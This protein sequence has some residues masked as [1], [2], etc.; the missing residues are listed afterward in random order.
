MLTIFEMGANV[1]IIAECTAVAS[2]DPAAVVI[3]NEDNLGSSSAAAVA[4][5]PAVGVSVNPFW[6][7]S[8]AKPVSAPAAAGVCSMYVVNALATADAGSGVFP[9]LGLVALAT[10]FADAGVK[11]IFISPRVACVSADAIAGVCV[12][13]IFP[14]AAFDTAD[15]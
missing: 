5:L 15:A 7:N 1:I 2:D 4:E 8:P 12:S 14:V 9:S 3:E 10:A 11:V 13:F 6:M